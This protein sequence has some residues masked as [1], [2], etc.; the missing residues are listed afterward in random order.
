ME[1]EKDPVRET[2]ENEELAARI[3]ELERRIDAI[4]R[5]LAGIA[6]ATGVP[7]PRQ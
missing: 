5:H 7:K 1:K 4:E 6:I 2:R 3:L